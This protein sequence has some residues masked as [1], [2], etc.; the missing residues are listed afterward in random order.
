M[1]RYL[2]PVVVIQMIKSGKTLAQRTADFMPFGPY[3]GSFKGAKW[4]FPKIRGT[5]FGGPYNKDP[6]I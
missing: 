1:A 5:L 6:I 2:K 3:L 4:E